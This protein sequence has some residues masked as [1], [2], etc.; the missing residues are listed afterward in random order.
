MRKGLV[1]SVVFAVV[2]VSLALPTGAQAAEDVIA[3]GSF[4]GAS[5]HAT[6]GSVSIVRTEAGAMVVLEQDFNFDGA[7]DPKVGFGRDG[8]YDARTQLGPLSANSG[9]Q[10]YPIP[11]SVDLTKYNEIYI[12]CKKYAVPL[13]V[14]KLQ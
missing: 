4:A 12:W 11:A 6:S 8:A 13:G 2:L 14:A 7:P 5:G 3:R 1:T 9:R 10:S